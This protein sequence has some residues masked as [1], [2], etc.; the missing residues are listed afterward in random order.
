MKKHT[1]TNKQY[2]I[3]VHQAKSDKVFCDWLKENGLKEKCFTLVP[4]EL[5]QAQCIATNILKNN[6]RYL[7]QN[8]AHTLNNFLFSMSR[9]DKRNNLTIKHAYTVMN[10][11]KAVNRKLFKAYKKSK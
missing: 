4:I 2:D 5:L 1:L 11:G 7:A 3:K 8:E 10:I 9:K 6:G